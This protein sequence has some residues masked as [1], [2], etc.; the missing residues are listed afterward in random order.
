VPEQTLE[1]LQR[2]VDQARDHIMELE[3]AIRDKLLKNDD[4][5]IDANSKI[6]RRAWMIERGRLGQIQLKVRDARQNIS[7][8]LVG[9]ESIR[10]YV[11]HIS[12][13]F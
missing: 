2:V 9:V 12:C 13:L 4:L 3:S 6:S 11:L 5:N 1:G 10:Q 8:A 7:L